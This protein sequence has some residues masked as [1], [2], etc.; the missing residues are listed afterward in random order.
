MIQKV[1]KDLGR[2]KVPLNNQ[3]PSH[4]KNDDLKL[5]NNQVHDQRSIGKKPLRSTDS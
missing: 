2:D 1:K 4:R 3:L 5:D